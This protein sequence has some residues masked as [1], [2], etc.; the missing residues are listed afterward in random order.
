MHA[1]AEIMKERGWGA[2]Q[3]LPSTLAAT[4]LD[5]QPGMHVL[6][7][8]AAPGGKTCAIADAMCNRGRIVAY[9]RTGD[10]S[11]LVKGMARQ[12]G[13]DGIVHACK[14]DSTALIKVSEEVKAKFSSKVQSLPS[15]PYPT[16]HVR[17]KCTTRNG[18]RHHLSTLA[19]FTSTCS[20]CWQLGQELMCAALLCSCHA[21]CQEGRLVAILA[22]SAILA[23]S[24]RLLMPSVQNRLH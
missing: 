18:T 20:L 7:M 13:H 5:A 4:L 10:K 8:C 11:L 6:D 12:Y 23:I 1:C 19:S 17:S 21:M 2:L 14:K 22:C 16:V 24:I 9:D 15:L 3:N